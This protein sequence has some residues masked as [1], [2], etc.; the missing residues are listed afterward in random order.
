MSVRRA[1]LGIE[2]SMSLSVRLVSLSIKGAMMSP[3]VRAA[4]GPILK[5]LADG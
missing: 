3:G 1:V 2:T 4:N 5:M